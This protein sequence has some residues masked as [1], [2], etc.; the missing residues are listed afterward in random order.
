[1]LKEARHAHDRMSERT[2]LSPGLVRVLERR[3][4]GLQP[5]REYY[6]PIVRGSTT[7]GFA[8]FGVYAGRATV[9]TILS[10]HMTPRGER[11]KEFQVDKIAFNVGARDGMMKAAKLTVGQQALGVIGGIG[12]AGI[13]AMSGKKE[14]RGRNALIGAAVGAGGGVALGPKAKALKPKATKKA[15]II[16]VEWEDLK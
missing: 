15:P 1:M 14:N 2:N 3:Y 11:L 9:K 10:P 12:G 7:L 13:G 5:G 16:D 4:R 6:A 8:V